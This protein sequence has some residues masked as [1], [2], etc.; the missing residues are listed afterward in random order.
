MSEHFKHIYAHR[1][2]EYDAMVGKED[3]QGHLLPAIE[4]FATLDGAH[5]VEFGAG[6][7]RLTRLLAPRAAS[8]LALD[9]AL[10]MLAHARNAIHTDTVHWAVGDNRTMPVASGIADITIAGWSFGHATG[11]NPKGWATDIAL[12]VTEME[13]ITKPGG[14]LII[15]ETLGTGSIT[16]TP[17]T[18]ALAAYYFWL[19]TVVGFSR[20]V[21]R[22]DYRFESVEEA[23]RLTRFFFGD[24]LADRIQNEQLIIVP[25]CTG[26]WGK[27]KS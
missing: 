6:T 13:R 1:V 2:A 23:D 22:T 26:V 4:A 27:Q 19:E 21:I 14:S 25:E 7:G 11:W 17:P 8:I 16:P 24:A 5:I 3:Y 15:I 18:T 20:Q 9:I 12:M 10:P